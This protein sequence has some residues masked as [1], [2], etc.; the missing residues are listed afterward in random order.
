MTRFC[1]NWKGGLR[2]KILN[3]LT[4]KI[5]NSLLVVHD[6]K[7]DESLDFWRIV[8][9]EDG[10]LKWRIIE[11]LHST[12]I[13]PTL[14]SNGPLVGFENPSTGEGCW[15]MFDSSWRTGRCVR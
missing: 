6:Q 7:Q 13:A 3:N 10:E 4:F 8:V 5:R 14:V 2:Q 11:E 9:P 15:E 1:A 12:P